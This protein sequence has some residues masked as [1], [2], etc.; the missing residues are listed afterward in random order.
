MKVHKKKPNIVSV[1]FSPQSKAALDHACAERGMTIKALLGRLIEW[2]NSLNK[3]E[4]SIVLG[5][6]DADDVRPLAKLLLQHRPRTG[7]RR[8][9][10]ARRRARG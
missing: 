10:A 9:Q 1:H 8:P 2:F 7:D 3:T 4:Q 6:V 5:Q